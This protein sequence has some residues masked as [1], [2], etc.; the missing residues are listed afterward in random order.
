MHIS[1]LVYIYIYIWL[2]VYVCVC[3]CVYGYP[4][5]LLVPTEWSTNI[6]VASTSRWMMIFSPLIFSHKEVEVRWSGCQKG[7]VPSGNLA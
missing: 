4:Q 6:G 5:L 7:D 2:Y 3:L 1:Y